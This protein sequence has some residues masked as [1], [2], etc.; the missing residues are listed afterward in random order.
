VAQK[1][2]S[3]K[4]STKKVIDALEKALAERKKSIADNE[5][6]K[7][8]YDKA[9]TEF[10]DSLAEMFRSGKGK[11]TSVSKAHN[12]RYNEENN[13]YEITVEF[14]ASV[15][16]PKEPE[17]LNDWSMKSDIEELENAIAVLKMTDEETI[18]TSTYKGVARFI[19]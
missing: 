8:E 4:V 11:V 13:K 7:K 18:N 10:R 9:V 15:K 5:K 1:P 3:V 6:A 14:P 17:N 19:K 2:I 12:F 16:A